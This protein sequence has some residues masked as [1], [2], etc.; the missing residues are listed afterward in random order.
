MHACAFAAQEMGEQAMKAKTIRTWL[1]AGVFCVAG[2]WGDPVP[3]GPISDY[4]VHCR[5]WMTKSAQSC[6]QLA[7]RLAVV[8]RPTRADR[9]ALLLSR[10]ALEREDE[11][12]G[13][14]EIAADH[15][16]Y[17]YALYFR[18]H[19]VPWVASQPGG[20]S[21]LALLLRAAEIEPDN[22]LVLEE[23]LALAEGFPPEA[24][25]RGIVPGI[26]AEVDRLGIG[27][28]ML[29]T[30]RETM[31]E[32][33]RA[34]ADWWRAVDAEPDD[35]PTEEFWQ[36]T[37]WDGPV[38]AARHIH[39]A[40]VRE[41]DQAAAERIQTRLRRDLGLD[42]LDYGAESARASLALACH[43]S[44]PGYLGLE[45][46][47]LAGVET[48]ARRASADGLPLPDYVL[49]AIAQTT[50]TLRHAACAASTGASIGSGRLV[51][52]DG[53]CQ[54]GVTETAAVRRLRAVLEHHG[55]PRSSEHHRVHAQGFLGDD[56]RRE[57]LHTA[58]KAD[59]ENAQARC[60]LAQA[61]MRVDPDA[62]VDVLGE[63]GDPSC[64]GP[65]PIIWGDL[66][67]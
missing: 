10:A 64:L 60:D 45:E 23:L 33:G 36:A 32:A 8:E 43:A 24:G 63:A 2:S 57:S 13:L 27:T 34:H 56:A 11:C 44:L 53:D 16:D 22:Y 46:V 51:L 29:A 62:A 50:G 35:P 6:A 38:T 5:S 9:L 7:D 41:G 52:L 59:P 21:A 26:E 42:N 61:L 31:Y 54:P 14:A 3:T 47:C 17:A 66:R 39:A 67:E 49:K 65:G 25:G 55:G 12:P 18:S 4:L 28:D 30:W 37:V 20:E 48:L 15:P 58:L 19:C 1:A 40:A